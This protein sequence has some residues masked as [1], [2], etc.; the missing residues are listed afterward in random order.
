MA[1]EIPFKPNSR[2]AAYL[3]DSGGMD[4]ELSVAQ[5][6]EFVTQWCEEN[7]LILTAV[8]ADEKRKGSSTIGRSQFLSMIRFFE[9][10]ACQDQGV[11]IWKLSRFAREVDDS[12][13]YRSL[14]RIKGF[15]VHS[16]KD[17]VPDND[18]GRLYES[19]IDFTNSR[20][21]KD[22]SEDVKRGLHHLLNTYGAL[23]GTPPRGFI[24]EP[25][26]IGKR[27]DGSTHNACRWVPDPAT[28]NKCLQAWVMRAA[29]VSIRE[30]HKELQLF[31]SRSSYTAF[32]TNRLY[33][34]ELHYSD[35]VIENYVE[36]LINQET[37]D[38]VQAINQTNWIENDP[39]R[40]SEK[41]HPRR[42]SSDF[43]LSGFLFCPRCGSPMNGKSVSFKGKTK[44]TYY[45]CS[46]AQR[47]MNCDARSIPQS[48][49][50]QLVIM[51]FKDVILKPSAILDRSRKLIKLAE[52]EINGFDAD[53]Q[54]LIQKMNTNK[55][56][57]DNLVDRIAN[58]PNAPQSIIDKIK[59]FELDQK[60]YQVK[61]E[62]LNQ[63]KESSRATSITKGRA[64]ELSQ[65]LSGLM[66]TEDLDTKRTILKSL[67]KRVTAERTEKK[68]RAYITYWNPGDS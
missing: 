7:K 10:P 6:R 60:K 8:F 18:F 53:H 40:R 36:P 31:S 42:I 46:N 28:W 26:V 34:G 4:Q 38:A 57:I 9:D 12:Q 14:L 5:Q 3:R 44:M 58:D 63:K 33:L 25:V 19:V 41:T 35:M 30:I 15:I 48:D 68:I 47:H 62:Y 23:P 20:F 1:N 56:R 59:E 22:M 54:D 65:Y 61:L 24:R 17:D 49:L 67:I 27:R 37:W 32:F 43:M 39:H 55:S 16:L 51:G 21:L 11:I 52:S 50:E 13:Y 66:D 64:L 29:G 45:S 2:V